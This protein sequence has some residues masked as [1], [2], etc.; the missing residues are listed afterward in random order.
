MAKTS[1]RRRKFVTEYLKDLNGTQAAIRSGF[2]ENGASVTA[3]RL[4]ANAR[5]KAQIEAELA[6]SG[7]SVSRTL[8]EI[9]RLSYSDVGEL[10][11]GPNLRPINELPEHARAAIAG[12]K[13]IKKNVTTGDGKTDDIHEVKLWDKT[14]ALEMAGKYLKLFEDKTEINTEIVIRWQGDETPAERNITPEV[15]QIGD[16]EHNS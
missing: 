11:D 2:S 7:L 8:R 5:I 12:I 14:K 3:S 10:F 9:A 4:L 1:N 16:G 6:D 15:K 13:V